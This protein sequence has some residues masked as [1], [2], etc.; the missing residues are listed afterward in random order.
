MSGI[1]NDVMVFVRQHALLYSTVKDDVIYIS[2]LSAALHVSS[3]K[4]YKI[5]VSHFQGCAC[6][7]QTVFSADLQVLDS[8]PC[9]GN[10]MMIVARIKSPLIPHGYSQRHYHEYTVE[11][12]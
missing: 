12:L 5:H 4:P 11:P 2:T 6:D 3:V 1:S 10:K 7:M 8:C 9:V